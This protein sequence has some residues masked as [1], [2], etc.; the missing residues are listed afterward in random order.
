MQRQKLESVEKRARENREAE[1]SKMRLQT[2]V[3][4]AHDLDRLRIERGV[5]IPAYVA[6]S[7]ALN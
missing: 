6:P 7:N 2:K 4:L 1:E 3:Q 5:P